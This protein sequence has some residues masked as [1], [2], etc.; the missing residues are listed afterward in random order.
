MSALEGEFEGDW[1]DDGDKDGELLGDSDGEP[2]VDRDGDSEGDLE[3][4]GPSPDVRTI[5]IKQLYH[6]IVS[7]PGSDPLIASQNGVV[8]AT[9]FAPSSAEVQKVMYRFVLFDW[10]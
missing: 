10:P 6:G 2:D 8:T 4:T 5:P 1:L 9:Q 3:D 7:P